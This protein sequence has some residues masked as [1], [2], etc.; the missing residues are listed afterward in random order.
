MLKVN[1]PEKENML[2]F[3]NEST[4]ELVTVFKNGRVATKEISYPSIDAFLKTTGIEYSDSNLVV[5]DCNNKFAGT[6]ADYIITEETSDEKEHAV[7]S[8]E[9]A[10]SS[11]SDAEQKEESTAE[12]KEQAPEDKED[13]EETEEQT[14]A[15]ENETVE[16][17][18]ESDENVDIDSVILEQYRDK[19][20]RVNQLTRQVNATDSEVVNNMSDIDRD[21][22][23]GQT[24][25]IGKG[26]AEVAN[27][28]EK[29]NS[30][31]RDRS[32]NKND[33]TS[34]NE[35]VVQ[36]ADA[37]LHHKSFDSIWLPGEYTKDTLITILKIRKAVM[38]YSAPGTGKTTTAI[39][40][41][42]EFA[43]DASRVTLVQFSE[44]Y[45]YT[46]FIGGLRPSEDTKSGFKYTDGIFT[47]LCKKAYSDSGNRYVLVIDEINRTKV[48]EVIGEM[49]NLMER[50]GEPITIRNDSKLVMPSN[51]FIVA[52]MNAMDNGIHKM[53]AATIDR[54][55]VIDMSEAKIDID[56]LKPDCGSLLKSAMK[57]VYEA[58]VNINEYL[59]KDI[60]GK[61]NIIGPRFL[62]TDYSS[63][64]ELKLIVDT[65]V[66]PSISKKEQSLNETDKERIVGLVAKMDAQLENYIEQEKDMTE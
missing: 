1:I 66:K 54:F 38:F 36:F 43:G 28:L 3:R 31:L 22:F 62:F 60:K 45:S 57:K 23:I 63:V 56:S 61:Q 51:L 12:V 17:E 53:S 35:K 64:S 8:T 40:L 42:N 55:A 7:E 14:V 48:E 19:K 29:I 34:E 32:S 27:N 25:R 39:A 9:S 65:S 30:Q 49:M 11:A 2:V 18:K 33:N 5:I 24:D 10:S 6:L 59:E 50:R 13:T 16:S 47:K 46:D 44:N 37:E 15:K 20:K 21:M 4:K 26:I 52:T 58:V 41:A